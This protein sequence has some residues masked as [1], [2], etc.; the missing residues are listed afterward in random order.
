LKEEEIEEFMQVSPGN[1]VCIKDKRMQS[2]P[3]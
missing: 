2:F 3:Q 1:R